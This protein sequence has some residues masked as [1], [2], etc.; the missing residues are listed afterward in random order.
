MKNVECCGFTPVIG[1]GD[2]LA[3]RRDAVR[4]AQRRFWV[5]ATN[6]I[7]KGNCVHDR[8]RTK[9]FYIDCLPWIDFE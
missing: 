4:S 3:N 8:I 7:C 1:L 6:N 9:I 5:I 2:L